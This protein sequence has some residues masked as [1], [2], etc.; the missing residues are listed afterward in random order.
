M[1]SGIRLVQ[2]QGLLQHIMY[3][4]MNTLLKGS[5]SRSSATLIYSGL[6]TSYMYQISGANNGNYHKFW[7]E[8]TIA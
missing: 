3:I 2:T 7:V 1:Y 6:N 8:T 5:L 4:N